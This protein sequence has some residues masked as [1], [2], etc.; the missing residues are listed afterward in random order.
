MIAKSFLRRVLIASI[1]TALVAT[2]V[3]ADKGGQGKGGGKPDKGASYGKGHGGGQGGGQGNKGGNPGK[4]G[5]Q[6]NAASKGKGSKKFETSDRSVI[7]SYYRDEYSR[8]GNCPPGLAKKNNGCMPPGQARKWNVGSTLP[9][10]IYIEPLPPALRS[11]LVVPMPGYDYG[12][13]GGEVILFG[14][15]DRI[16]VDFVAVF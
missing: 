16:V 4:G 12:Y 7:Q 9:S 6:G 15:S 3:M 5:G 13:V 8:S 10:D 2:P 1:A 11:T 14:V